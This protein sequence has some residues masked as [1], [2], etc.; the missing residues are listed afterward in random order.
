[1]S[2][3]TGITRDEL[4]KSLFAQLVMMFTT[5]ALQHL[6]KMSNPMTKAV[7]V[8]LE[9]AQSTIDLLDMLAEKTS[10]NLDE[11]EEAMVKETLASLKMNFVEVKN[12]GARPPSPPPEPEPSAPAA[13]ETA[14]PSPRDDIQ[15]S[16]TSESKQPKFHKK[17]D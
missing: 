4:H 6:G 15:E 9:A 11:D 16:S 7:D 5:S 10:G 3:S 17:Y 2:T 14:E 13:N 12:A 1:M 8:D